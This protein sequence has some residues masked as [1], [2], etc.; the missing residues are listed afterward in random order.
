MSYYIL[1]QDYT[2]SNIHLTQFEKDNFTEAE[3][4]IHLT[5]YQEGA[6]LLK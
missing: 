6:Q 2:S 1:Y 4:V 3:I 5:C